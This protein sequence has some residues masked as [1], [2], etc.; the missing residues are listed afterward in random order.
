VKTRL[1]P[2]QYRPGLADGFLDQTG[3]GLTVRNLDN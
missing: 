2:M 1:K 3:L